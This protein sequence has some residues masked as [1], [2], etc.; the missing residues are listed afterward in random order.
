MKKY[1]TPEINVVLFEEEVMAEI[2]ISG[3]EQDEM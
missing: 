2:Q 3:I 1:E